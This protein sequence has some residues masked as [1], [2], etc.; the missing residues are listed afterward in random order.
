M[1]EKGENE[2]F[3]LA[4]VAVNVKELGIRGWMKGQG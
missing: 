1:D 2:S 4:Q 3:A